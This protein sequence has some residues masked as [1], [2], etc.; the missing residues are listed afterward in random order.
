MTRLI[1]LLIPAVA[2]G[3][4]S[5]GSG[6][7]TG[8][9]VSSASTTTMKSTQTGHGG[10][11]SRPREYD[12]RQPPPMDPKREVTEQDCSKPVD[13]SKGNLKCK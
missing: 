4:P 6:G 10:G 7:K 11:S 1:L 13:L 5:P 3:A 2:L 9:D 12:P 8:G